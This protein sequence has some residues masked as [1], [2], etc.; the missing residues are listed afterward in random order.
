MSEELIPST[1]SM[2]GDSW[3][4]SGISRSI[5]PEFENRWSQGKY[6]GMLLVHK[7]PTEKRAAVGL[8][9]DLY[10]LRAFSNAL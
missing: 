10:S 8:P 5:T 1:F 6:M 3:K 4:S 2:L 7:C 9:H